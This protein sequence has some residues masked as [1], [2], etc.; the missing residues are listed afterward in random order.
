MAILNPRK[1]F[2]FTVSIIPGPNLEPFSVQQITLS[3]SVIE[4]VE[5]GFG[6]TILKTAGQ[7]KAGALSMSII[8]SSSD[9]ALEAALWAWH[10]QAQNPALQAGGDPT[11]VGGYKRT[12]KVEELGSVNSAPAVVNTWFVIGAW[13]ATMNGK[14]FDRTASDNT[15]RSIEFAVDYITQ[16]DVAL[17][18]YA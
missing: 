5:H 16:E 10:W 8:Q 12:I 14:E 6:N 7:I 2:N 1:K 9:G 4:Q 13:P 15:V 11:A 17:E 3:D 18:F